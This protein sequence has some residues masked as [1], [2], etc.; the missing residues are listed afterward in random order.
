MS[1]HSEVEMFTGGLFYHFMCFHILNPGL[2]TSSISV[3]LPN[4]LHVKMV[5]SFYKWEGNGA[6]IYVFSWGDRFV[7]KVGSS[8]DTQKQQNAVQDL[9]KGGSLRK[10]PRAELAQYKEQHALLPGPLEAQG[11]CSQVSAESSACQV[12]ETPALGLQEPSCLSPSGVFWL[13]QA[14]L[15]QK[16]FPSPS[17]GSLSFENNREF[18]F[19]QV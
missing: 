3:S 11:R 10:G 7:R 17:V 14:V 6:S 18:F 2:N 19:C 12:E 1:C 8:L 13:T 5:S 4:I 15:P 16:S 9:G